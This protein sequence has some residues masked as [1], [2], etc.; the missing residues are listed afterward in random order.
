MLRLT[1]DK[2]G[3]RFS[4]RAKSA[5]PADS[6]SEMSSDYGSLN[7]AGPAVSFEKTLSAM[8]NAMNCSAV[9]SVSHVETRFDNVVIEQEP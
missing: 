2:L 4:C 6:G 3:R 1:W 5:D 9:R 7:V 8:T